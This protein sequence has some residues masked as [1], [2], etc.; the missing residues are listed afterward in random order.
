MMLN[1]LPHQF[2][3]KQ[4]AHKLTGHIST[5]TVIVRPE[6]QRPLKAEVNTKHGKTLCQKNRQAVANR[7]MN[8]G[9][10]KLNIRSTGKYLPLCSSL[11][12]H[13]KKKKNVQNKT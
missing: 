6:G 10:G 1:S 11:N 7:P 3:R 5:D 13:R 4:S 2:L 8:T 9:A 12:V